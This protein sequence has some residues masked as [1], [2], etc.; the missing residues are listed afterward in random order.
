MPFLLDMLTCP[1]GLLAKL[2]VTVHKRQC[3]DRIEG[4]SIIRQAI[5]GQ[6]GY[7]TRVVFLGFVHQQDG[8]GE[9][10]RFLV[11]LLAQE[12]VG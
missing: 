10:T 11:Q 5:Q 2:P 6:G 3:R 9:L 4:L 7:D 1:L 12:F 8:Q